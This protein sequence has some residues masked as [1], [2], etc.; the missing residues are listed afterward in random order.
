[1]KLMLCT[2]QGAS[3]YS[4]SFV[5]VNSNLVFLI[6]SHILQIQFYMDLYVYRTVFEHFS[7]ELVEHQLNH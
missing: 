4:I 5:V 1:M 3:E 2:L 6:F 7:F